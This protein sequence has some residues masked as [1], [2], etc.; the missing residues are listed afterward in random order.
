MEARVRNE[1]K[2]RGRVVVGG[3]GGIW[4]GKRE[5][6][7]GEDEDD[8]YHGPHHFCSLSAKQFLINKYPSKQHFSSSSFS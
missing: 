4:K 8:K 1:R 7:E 6:K 5:R 3:G 2:E